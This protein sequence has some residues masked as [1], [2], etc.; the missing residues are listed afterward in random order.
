MRARYNF[1]FAASRSIHKT[2]TCAMRH[3]TD[4]VNDQIVNNKQV[5][6]KQIISLLS[7]TLLQC[8]LFNP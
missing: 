3:T 1:A 6:T 5:F 2:I 7:K 4:V 8:C